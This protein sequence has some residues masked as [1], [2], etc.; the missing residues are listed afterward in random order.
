[1]VIGCYQKVDVGKLDEAFYADERWVIGVPWKNMSWPGRSI[2]ETFWMGSSIDPV[3]PNGKPRAIFIQTWL[4]KSLY[5]SSP[6]ASFFHSNNFTVYIRLYVFL[7][8][9]KSSQY[10]HCF[11]WRFAW[12]F[13][14][15]GLVGIWEDAATS[16]NPSISKFWLS[17]SIPPPFHRSCS[18]MFLRRPKF[19]P[20]KMAWHAALERG[21]K[22]PRRIVYEMLHR[23]AKSLLLLANYNCNNSTART[24]LRY[25]K[26]VCIR[27]PLQPLQKAQ[28]QPRFGPSVVCSAIHAS[29]QLTS[30]RF[31]NFE[32]S[33]TALCG[34]T[35]NPLGGCSH[36]HI[37]CIW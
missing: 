18:F 33:A 37:R 26:Q 25:I 7:F 6:P 14:V 20:N 32:T 15:A 9:P 35:G 2:W 8:P 1:M 29:Q 5:W 30:H 19:C 21:P 17:P 22:I 36:S 16:W 24:T 3:D 28:L 13:G 34:T 23:G 12:L 10:I 11:L 27:W 31:P 4:D